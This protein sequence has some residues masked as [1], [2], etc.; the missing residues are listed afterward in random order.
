[1]PGRA[2]RPH[3]DTYGEGVIITNHSKLQS[4][5][6]LMNQRLPIKSQIVFKLADILN[7]EIVL[8]TIYNREEA[9]IHLSVGLSS[10]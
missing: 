6:S 9:W 7:T 5:L 8:G 10:R 1:M 3:H 2:R 4:Y